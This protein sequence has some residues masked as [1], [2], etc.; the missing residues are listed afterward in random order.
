MG[1]KAAVVTASR[2]TDDQNDTTYGHENLKDQDYQ[3]DEFNTL[4][5]GVGGFYAFGFWVELAE[6]TACCG[7]ARKEAAS[8]AVTEFFFD[9]GGVELQ[10][11][12]AGMYRSMLVQIFEQIPGLQDPFTTLRLNSPDTGYF[13]WTVEP[14][15][16][17]LTQTVRNLRAWRWTCFINGMNECD[18]AQIDNTLVFR[19]IELLR[20]NYRYSISHPAFQVAAA[21]I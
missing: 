1:V 7:Q 17:L 9:A 6:P 11:T 18:G 15:K 19:R 2:E 3:V 14:L 10:H 20:L 4:R 12:A 5:R 16:I 8:T 21:R 13:G